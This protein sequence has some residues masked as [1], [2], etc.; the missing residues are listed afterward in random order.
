MFDDCS[1]SLNLRTCCKIKGGE[2]IRP[3]AFLELFI[4]MFYYSAN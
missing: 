4:K 1:T 2:T 3:S